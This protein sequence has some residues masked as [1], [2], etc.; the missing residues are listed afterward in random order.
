[1]SGATYPADAFSKSGT[2]N[3]GAQTCDVY[4]GNRAAFDAAFPRLAQSAALNTDEL[5]PAKI[6]RAEYLVTVCADKR[7][8]RLQYSFDAP[9]KTK[10]DTKGALTYDVQLSGYDD[11]ITIQAPADAVPLPGASDAPTSAPEATATKAAPGS[12]ANLDGE[13]EG[14]SSTDSPLQFTVE[15][16]K[17][18]YANLNYS[19]NTGGCSVGGAYGT[20]IDDGAITDKKFTIA[21]TNSDD[22]K[23][24]FAGTF[25][26]NGEA[27][28]TLNIKGKTFCGDTDANATWTATHKS[29]PDN[30]APEATTAAEPTKAAGDETPEAE[31][32]GAAIVNALVTALNAGNVDDAAILFGDDSIFTF[33]TDVAM[34]AADIKAKLQSLVS[35]NAKFSVSDAN[36][37]GGLVT[38]KL[39]GTG[40]NAGTWPNSSAILADGKIAIL[41]IK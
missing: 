15:N 35:G 6:T 1:M 23:F 40:S 4:T 36:D 19:V 17:I 26:S 22:V 38:F 37:L 39:Q 27:A 12:F 21:L 18:T 31:A 34:G 30:P 28:G 11:A 13:W 41:T 3:V 32:D 24:T 29:S 20:S 8:Y 16:N 2:A 10:P 7:L 33:D 25:T 9:S 5:D 14:T